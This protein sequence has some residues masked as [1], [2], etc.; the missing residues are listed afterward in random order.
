MKIIRR[1]LSLVSIRVPYSFPKQ[2]TLQLEQHQNLYVVFTDPI[3]YSSQD[4]LQIFSTTALLQNYNSLKAA[5]T[6]P[7]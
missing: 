4:Q 3:I 6:S 7:I 2:R 5:I 1:E